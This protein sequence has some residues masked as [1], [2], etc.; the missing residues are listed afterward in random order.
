MRDN[1]DNGKKSGPLGRYGKF[2]LYLVVVVLLNLVGANLFTRIDLTANRIYS[3]SPVSKEAVATLTE[4]LT[5]KVFFTPNL[6]APYN[7]VERYVHDLLEEYALAGNRY[8]NFQFYDTG[9]EGEKAD[10]N[11]ALASSYGITPVQIRVIDKDEVKF[12]KAYMGLAIIH[13]DLVETLPA[14]TRTEG[15]EYRLT[16]TIRRMNNKISR[17]QALP[18]KV[19]VDL[20]LSSS[21]QVVG[22]YLN[23]EHLKK[24]PDEIKKVV[25]ELNQRLYDRLDFH[26]FDPSRDPAAAEAAR[27]KRIM[28]LKWKGFTDRQGHTIPGGN[29]YAGLVVSYG[30]Q[31]RDLHLISAVKVPIFGTQYLLASVGEIKSVLDG[32]VSEVIGI[33]EKIG[34]LS[35]HG[36]LSLQAAM[37]MP[38][39]PRP[40]AAANFNN[41]LSQEYD[42]QFVTLDKPGSLA[43]IKTLIIARPTK[44]FSDYELYL[45]DQFL[46][47]GNRLALFYDP[48]EEKMPPRN[49][50]MMAR[51]PSYIPL[52]TGLEKLLAHYGAK[53]KPAY[54]MDKKCYKQQMPQSQGGG[55]RPL[56][57]VPMIENRNINKEF[58]FIRNIKGLIMLKAAPIELD[59]KKLAQAGITAAS[60]IAS[61]KDS[62]LLEKH[63]DLNPMLLQP[64]AE[65]SSYA[66]YDLAALLSGEFTSYFRG[67]PLPEKPETENK[68][69]KPDKDKAKDKLEQTDKSSGPEAEK[70]AALLKE[71]G[72]QSRGGR[73]DRGRGEIIVVA[74]AAILKNNVVD[75]DGATPNA[76]FLMNLVDHL[77]GRDALAELRSKTQRFNPLR[78]V[79]PET[80][81]LIKGLNLVGLPLLVV[82]VGILAWFRRGARRRKLRRMFAAAAGEKA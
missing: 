6:P 49:M 11:Q 39:Q 5:F 66:S 78:P 18:G 52:N 54:V 67:K 57:F 24:M 3:L 43:G 9:G 53:I 30:D 13:G 27:A 77:N 68:N 38:G 40:E 61:S 70:A 60:L 42:P 23:L 12:Q 76:Q 7:G 20:Y 48:F 17:L 58:P 29:G 16:T 82:L 28:E 19:K 75:E 2:I 69:K 63:I 65:A 32:V 44:P 1:I 26:F 34:W 55:Q 14:I 36:T 22:P 50:M 35:D 46:L 41:L 45:L 33:N 15:L 71:G 25:S 21:L 74:S 37:A 81:S 62:W 10:E 59:R 79:A 72:L 4:P 64:P 31:C 51:G 56:Y 8:F 47:Q 80:R 73:L